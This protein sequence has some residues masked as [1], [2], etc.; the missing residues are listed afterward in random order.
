[1]ERLLLFSEVD[2]DCIEYTDPVK[3]EDKIYRN[4]I[5]YNSKKL[6][7][8]TSV[9][10]NKNTVEGNFLT[11]ELNGTS[12]TLYNF[13]SEI[14]SLN[15]LAAKQY[16]KEWFGQ[17]MSLEDLN[18]MYKNTIVP[19]KDSD[20][21]P[22]IRIRISENVK[23]FDS[24]RKEAPLALVNGNNITVILSLKGLNFCATAFNTNWEIAQI[25]VHTQ[26]KPKKAVLN[27]YAFLSDPEPEFD[28]PTESDSE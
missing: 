10:R 21:L 2:T 1:M 26:L 4:I 15:I 8:Q 11:A 28:I 23:V 17:D 14:D 27:E 7:I 16:S 9:L 25:K 24:D 20:S 22:S 18:E 5:T 3:G 6:F 13:F 12:K 19:A